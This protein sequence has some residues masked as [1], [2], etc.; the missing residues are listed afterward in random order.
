MNENEEHVCSN[1]GHCWHSGFNGTV[2]MDGWGSA[3][4]DVKPDY[5][6][7]DWVPDDEDDE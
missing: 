3:G 6:C 1:C 4:C 2:C 7:D 5:S